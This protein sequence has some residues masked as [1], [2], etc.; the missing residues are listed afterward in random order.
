MAKRAA[1]L[2]SEALKLDEA[3]RAELAGLLFESL[4]PE[5]DEGVEAAWREE[6]ER[7]M[8]ALDKGSSATIPWSEVRAR[9]FSG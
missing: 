9:L 5:A 8:K 4:E 1:D 3:E 7:R 2:Y 6:I